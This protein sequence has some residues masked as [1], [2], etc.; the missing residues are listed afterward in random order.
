MQAGDA[1][2]QHRKPPC[3]RATGLAGALREDG[4]IQHI[5]HQGGSALGVV[6]RA[7]DQQATGAFVRHGGY[8]RGVRQTRRRQQRGNFGAGLVGVLAPPAGFA[9]IHKPD[10]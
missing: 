5:G 7:D 9:N 4:D 8:G 2:A 1:P 10:G 3:L 6:Q